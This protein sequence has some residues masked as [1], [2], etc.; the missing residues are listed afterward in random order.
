MFGV[1]HIPAKTGDTL[2]FNRVGYQPATFVV[3]DLADHVISLDAVTELPVVTVKEN[4]LQAN[5]REAKLGYRKK[6]VFYTGTPHYYYLLVK[7]MTFIY[8]NFK[9]EVIQA[10][11]FNR[12]AKTELAD[13]EVLIRWNEERIKRNIAIADSDMLNFKVR[14]MPTLKQINAM[15]DYALAKYIKNC[16]IDFKANPYN[17]GEL[18]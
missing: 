11:K 18:K 9:S 13:F 10:R 14:Y 15:N 6:A 3:K 16:Y 5:I 8:E 17:Q 1:F 2:L 12:L 7:P 4:S